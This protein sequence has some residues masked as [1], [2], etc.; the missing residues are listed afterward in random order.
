MHRAG[1]DLEAD[2]RACRELLVDQSLQ[3]RLPLG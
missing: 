3:R 1:P 2:A